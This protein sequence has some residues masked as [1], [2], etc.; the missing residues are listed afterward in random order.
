MLERAHEK[1]EGFG[2]LSRAR[3]ALSR[4]E[5]ERRGMTEAQWNEEQQR[6]W[7]DKQQSKLALELPPEPAAIEALKHI[8]ALMDSLEPPPEI[9]LWTPPSYAEQMA[10]S[11]EWGAFEPRQCKKCHLWAHQAWQMFEV[12]A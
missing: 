2:H 7:A 6:I 8:H 10:C 12:P 5:W 1:N 4:P 11:H 9:E 3:E